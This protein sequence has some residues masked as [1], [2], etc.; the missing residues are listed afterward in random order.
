MPISNLQKSII[1]DE[2]LIATT[3]YFEK[4]ITVSVANV[5]HK[6]ISI[7]LEHVNDSKAHSF[8]VKT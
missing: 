7:C 8:G 3:Q 2:I 4:T 1:G 6:K 5:I